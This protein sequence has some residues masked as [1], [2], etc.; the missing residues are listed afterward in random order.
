MTVLMKIKTYSKIN[1]YLDVIGKY[2][3]GFHEIESIFQ[4]VSLGDILSFHEISEGIQ[5]TTNDILLPIDE[6]NIVYRTVKKIKEITKIKKGIHIH[7]QKNIPVCAGLGGGSSNSAGTLYALNKLWNLSWDD[8]TLQNIASELGSDVPYFLKGGTQAVSGKGEKL[9]SLKPIPE[10]WIV[11]IHPSVGLSTAIVYQH[12]SLKV[13]YLRK[14][15][16]KDSLPFKKVKITLQNRDWKRVIYNR[17]EIPAF[18]IYPEL[19]KLKLRIKHLGFP[20]VGMTGSGSTFFV[21]VESK[22]KGEKLI[23]K[24][25]YNTNLV[26][27]TSIAIQELQ[28]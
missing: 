11:L 13:R 28:L 27:T 23:S 3:D 25:N 10:T 1:L 22:N 24:L 12:P 4:T 7:I 18:H 16:G 19:Y 15:K 2:S 17:L 14:I 20:Y 9:S 6:K 21:I 26:R 8:V 5:I